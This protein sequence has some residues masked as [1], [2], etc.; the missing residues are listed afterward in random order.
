MFLKAAQKIL[1]FILFA[2]CMHKTVAQEIRV[3]D[4][5]GTLEKVNNNI[6]T[7]SEL[8]PTTPAPFKGDI[9]INNVSTPNTIKI[10]NDA[11]WQDITHTGAKGSVFFAA[12]NGVPSENNNQFYWDNTNNKLGVGTNSPTNKL[13]VSGTIGTQG[14]LISNGTVGKPSFTFKNDTDTGIFRPNFED[15]MGFAAG[16]IE[17][18]HIEEDSNKTLVTIK[19]TIKL[20]EQLLDETNSSGTVGQVLKATATGTKWALAF[21]FVENELIFDGDDDANAKNDNYRYVSLKINGE[22]KVVRYDKTDVNVE[23][24]ATVSNN[25]GQT[26]QPTTLA[27]CTALK[28]I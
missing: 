4:N 26:T 15:E 7:S 3:I 9:W 16:G 5:K 18:I 23:V 25:P 22:W 20:E 21:N 19:H 13:E 8:A 27:V 1:I 17:A 6:V 12:T 28:Y 14:I 2:I 11:S 10:Y 24:V